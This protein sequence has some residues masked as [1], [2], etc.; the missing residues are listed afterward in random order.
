METQKFISASFVL[1]LTILLNILGN[2]G[3]KLPHSKN[4][5]FIILM[6]FVQVMS[7]NEQCFI[8]AQQR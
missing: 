1:K 3:V 2:I 7:K 5:N 8:I 4:G 6:I